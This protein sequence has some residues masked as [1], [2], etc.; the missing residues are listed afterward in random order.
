MCGIA[1][2]LPL[3]P[4]TNHSSDEPLIAVMLSAMRHRGPDDLGIVTTPLGAVGASRLAILGLE[5]ASN[6][7]L[8]N[9]ESDNTVVFNG[10]VFNYVEI[11]NDLRKL[12]HSFLSTGDTEVIAHAY[13]EW[14]QDCVRHFNG[15][16][17]FLVVD[18]RSNKIFFARD[19]F[20][21]KPFYY[22]LLR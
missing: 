17:S 7:P 19:R 4:G 5:P 9:P 2:I 18:E 10:E 13:E 6:Q 11:R 12:G 22:T 8:R 15:M 3:K 1:G 21:V 16:F 20:G 14:G